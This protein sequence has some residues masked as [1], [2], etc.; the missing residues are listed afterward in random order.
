MFIY[1]YFRSLFLFDFG[2]RRFGYFLS[3][4]KIFIFFCNISFLGMYNVIYGVMSDFFE[5]LKEWMLGEIIC[6]N[7]RFLLVFFERMMYVIIRV[8]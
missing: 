4:W 8:R 6:V 2:I 7:I 5:I 1:D 3:W